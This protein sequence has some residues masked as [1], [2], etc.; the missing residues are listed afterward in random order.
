MNSLFTGPPLIAYFLYNNGLIYR[1]R[2]KKEKLKFTME[3]SLH[4]IME[5]DHIKCYRYNN[6]CIKKSNCCPFKN[7]D[8][9]YE[10][11]FNFSF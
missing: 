11:Y 2:I 4:H 1:R 5:L 6:Q 10:N 3:D 7:S 9:Y 8:N